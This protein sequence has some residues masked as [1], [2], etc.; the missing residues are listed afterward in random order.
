[1]RKCISAFAVGVVLLSV[2]GCAGGSLPT[3]PKANPNAPKEAA[4]VPEVSPDAA[5]QNVQSAGT[6][7]APTGILK[8]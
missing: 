4:Q 1:M 8:D 6:E 5:I 3:A 7:N 2:L